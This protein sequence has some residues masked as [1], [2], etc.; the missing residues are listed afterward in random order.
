MGRIGIGSLECTKYCACAK[1]IPTH[2]EST[3]GKK[4]LDARS[5]PLVHKPWP[6]V[7]PGL[8]KVGNPEFT[9]YYAHAYKT[10]PKH[11]KC[12]V[13]CGRRRSIGG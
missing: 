4:H 8:D 3:V 2:G 9:E 6:R 11:A 10:M 1:N 7:G 5:L 12:T 13:G